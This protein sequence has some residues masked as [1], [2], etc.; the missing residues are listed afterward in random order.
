MFSHGQK[1]MKKRKRLK[2]KHLRKNMV[3][4]EQPDIKSIFKSTYSNK[5][6]EGY[7]ALGDKEDELEKE[8][9]KFKSQADKALNEWETAYQNARS[10]LDAKSTT[11]NDKRN[12]LVKDDS[13]MIYY[14]DGNGVK[15]MFTTKAKN[16]LNKAATR[17]K[18]CPDPTV[19][20]PI[21]MTD[22]ELG[23]FTS[24]ANMDVGFPCKMGCY[25]LNKAAETIWVDARGK[26]HEY[27]DFEA[28]VNFKDAKTET[29]QGSDGGWWDNLM[30][31]PNKGKINPNDPNNCGT[32]IST[33]NVNKLSQKND[34]LINKTR[35]IM[36]KIK[37]MKDKRKI[38]ENKIGSEY[39]GFTNLREGFKEGVDGDVKWGGSYVKGQAEATDETMKSKLIHKLEKLKSKRDE[40][41]KERANLSTYNSQIEEQKLKINSVKMHH[42]I[43]MIMGGTFLLT[44]IINSR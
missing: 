9:Q 2:N 12:K 10:E 31:Q 26:A 43:W 7:E 3:S 13:D 38:I 39:S 34:K 1:F 41:K 23:E 17:P 21:S 36:T 32:G 30:A 25:N 5:L 18:G 24:G 37:S 40:I 28:S 4:V 14:I 8:K 16:A 35:D 6:K 11:M 44:A 19:S 33:S 22:A 29:I 20:S 27:S 42:L 15:R